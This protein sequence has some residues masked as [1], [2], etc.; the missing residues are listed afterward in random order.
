MQDRD[1]K[2]W[3]GDP[4][5]SRARLKA[6][7]DRELPRLK[8]LEATLRVEYEEP[9][10][11]EAEDQ[12]LAQVAKEETTLLRAE[13]MHEQSYDRAV[14][15]L[16]KVRKQS[17]AEPVPAAVPVP[18]AAALGARRVVGDPEAGRDGGGRG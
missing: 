6:I 13:R 12:A 5:A 7:V 14:K 4:A 1:L 2:L 16:I 9:A 11:A 3:P 10:R 17:A 18:A 15:S 8:S